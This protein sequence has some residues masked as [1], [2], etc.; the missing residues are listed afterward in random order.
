MDLETRLGTLATGTEAVAERLARAVGASG[1][2]A[3]SR[4]ARFGVVGV[5]A[6][7]I[8]AVLTLTLA[9]HMS[10]ALASLLAYCT[11]AVFSYTGH[12]FFT[13]VSTGGHRQEAPRFLML[14]GFGIFLSWAVAGLLSDWNDV[15]V[16]VPVTVNCVAIP[17]INFLAMRYWVFARGR[18]PSDGST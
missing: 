9:P 3:L 4:F 5:V 13:F 14:T 18:R 7:V 2:A 11:G 15:P 8:Y 1:T 10:A 12:K 17:T 6:T 16:A